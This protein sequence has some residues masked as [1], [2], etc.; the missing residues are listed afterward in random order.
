MSQLQPHPPNT[1]PPPDKELP[2]AL[3]P[4]VLHAAI[5]SLSPALELLERFHHR[6]KNQHRL[7]KWW[8]QADMLRRHVRKM[9]GE[10][11][12]G[13]AEAERVAKARARDEKKMKQNLGR[14]LLVD[15]VRKKSGQGGD[16]NKGG[17]VV[18]VKKRAEYLRWRLGPGAY[19]AFTQLS[20]DRQFAHLGL[21]LLGVLAQVD[22]A[23]VPFA[24][25]VSTEAA[26]ERAAVSDAQ[27]SGRGSG[28]AGDRGT[29]D[30][31]AAIRTGVDVDMGV[32]V[33]REEVLASIEQNEKTKA[34]AMSS[35]P[36][37]PSVQLRRETAAAGRQTSTA[38]EAGTDKA[39]SK[40]TN[41]STDVSIECLKSKKTK[42]KKRAGDEFD[43]IFGALD[44]SSSNKAPK[45]KKRKKGDEFD[46]IFGG[47]S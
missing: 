28:T 3:N 10:L 5:A 23:V 35:L 11:E 27:T 12:A 21:M 7:S 32:A 25:E 43:D 31:D 18:A 42:E 40:E 20:A 33:S 41:N 34:C 6:N 44:K 13:L 1:P 17:M 2:A 24:P 46:D 30:T 14:L 19:L 29:A 9:L 4:D 38:A 36:S 45:K 37:K 22:K 8:A 16:E 39:V 26:G 15:G 47:L